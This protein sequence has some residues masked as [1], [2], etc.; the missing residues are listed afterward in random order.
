MGQLPLVKAW[1][2]SIT[3]QSN[4]HNYFVDLGAE[5]IILLDSCCFC[6]DSCRERTSGDLCGKIDPLNAGATLPEINGG[7]SHSGAVRN[8]LHVKSLRAFPEAFYVSEKL[9]AIIP[10][11]SF[12]QVCI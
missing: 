1:L 2:L 5:G 8:A 6:S 9:L 11:G 12:P 4:D 3:S 10:V 7:A